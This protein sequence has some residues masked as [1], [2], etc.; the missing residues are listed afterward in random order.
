MGSNAVWEKALE[1]IESRVPKQIFDTWFTP[2]R[3]KE[4]EGSTAKIEVPNKFFGQW[5]I[6]HHKE[7]LSEAL[8]AAHGGRELTVLFVTSEKATMKAA[9]GRTSTARVVPAS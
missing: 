2:T 4:I 8:A 3:L 9:E 6:E 5:L 7:L 1:H